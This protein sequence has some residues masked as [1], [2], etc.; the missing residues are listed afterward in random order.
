MADVGDRTEPPTQPAFR[1]FFLLTSYPDRREVCCYS[2]LY[3]LPRELNQYAANFLFN[4]PTRRAPFSEETLIATLHS[5][6]TWTPTIS[7]TTPPYHRI[8]EPVGN[9]IPLIP[10]RHFLSLSYPPGY[11]LAAIFTTCVLTVRRQPRLPSFDF[12][13]KI[14]VEYK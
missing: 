6:E 10:H 1:D 11:I 14:L 12:R 8:P 3:S 13:G 5:P 4:L 9:L 2:I 7:I